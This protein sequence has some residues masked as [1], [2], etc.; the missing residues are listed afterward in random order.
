MDIHYRSTK[1]SLAA[2][3]LFQ[4]PE[5]PAPLHSCSSYS[6]SYF[7]SLTY[8]SYSCSHS[9]HHSCHHT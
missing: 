7:Y 4:S 1:K 6:Y 3:S 5:R 8:Y 2:R 9:S